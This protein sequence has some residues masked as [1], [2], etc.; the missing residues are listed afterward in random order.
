[1]KITYHISGTADIQP[2]VIAESILSLLN[3]PGNIILESAGIH[4]GG[5]QAQYFL[6]VNISRN[7]YYCA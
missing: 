3:K 1:M 7:S 6:L 2:N 5:E 4:L